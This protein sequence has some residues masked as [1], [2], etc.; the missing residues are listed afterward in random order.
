VHAECNELV[1]GDENHGHGDQQKQ[2]ANRSFH[3]LVGDPSL[4]TR[5]DLAANDYCR[6]LMPT[7]TAMAM[8]G[9]ADLKS[10]SPLR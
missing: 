3:G 8:N 6:H 10:I 4:H 2:A 5:T 7:G 1:I 9:S